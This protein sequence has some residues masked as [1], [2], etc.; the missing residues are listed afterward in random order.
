MRKR[1]NV[2]DPTDFEPT[3]RCPTAYGFSRNDLFGV[4]TFADVNKE[5]E[6][7]M[8]LRSPA[9]PSARV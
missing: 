5:G 4:R 7:G 8:I 6:V 3:P 9:H 1:L 2:R